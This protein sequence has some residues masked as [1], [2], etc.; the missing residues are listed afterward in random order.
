MFLVLYSLGSTLICMTYLVLWPN[1]ITHSL[2]NDTQS[3]CTSFSKFNMLLTLP[4]KHRCLANSKHPPKIPQT[5]FS[6]ELVFISCSREADETRDGSL[7]LGSSRG[8]HGSVVLSQGTL[9]PPK[10]QKVGDFWDTERGLDICQPK[11]RTNGPA[12]KL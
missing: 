7:A 6:H 2:A 9:P 10:P 3:Q 11:I 4:C 12:Q 5:L 8:G 1:P